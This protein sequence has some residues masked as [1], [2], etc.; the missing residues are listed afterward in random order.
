M[1]RELNEAGIG[2]VVRNENREVMASLAERITM[3]VSVEVLEALAFRKTGFA[4]HTKHTVEVTQ[5]SCSFM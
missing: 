2:V 4:S 3:V 1:F 5:V